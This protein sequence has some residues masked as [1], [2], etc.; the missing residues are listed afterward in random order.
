MIEP[1]LREQL[2]QR[3]IAALDLPAYSS[4]REL[5]P[6]LHA[7]LTAGVD[8]SGFQLLAD[9]DGSLEADEVLVIAR[10]GVPGNVTSQFEG[11]I[12]D[13]DPDG[14]FQIFADWCGFKPIDETQAAVAAGANGLTPSVAFRFEVLPGPEHWISLTAVQGDRHLDTLKIERFAGRDHRVSLGEVQARFDLFLKVDAD[15]SVAVVSS[16]IEDD[17][18]IT[19]LGCIRLPAETRDDLDRKVKSLWSREW[20]TAQDVD[21]ELER[22]GRIVAAALPDQLVRHL[23]TKTGPLTVLIEHGQNCDFPFELAYLADAEAE[24]RFLGERHRIIR[25]LPTSA[26]RP[27]ELRVA[28][29]ALIRNPG[30]LANSQS[31]LTGLVELLESLCDRVHPITTLSD[32]R[33]RVFRTS[34]YDVLDFVA[35]V[36][37]DSSRR[38]GLQLEEGH[39]NSHD[40]LI[41]AEHEFLRRKPFGFVNGCSATRESRGIFQST[42]FPKF[43]LELGASCF[44]GSSV[45]VQASDALRFAKALYLELNEDADIG[46]ATRRA[47]IQ[48][49]SHDCPAP[50]TQEEVELH[51]RRLSSLSYV[52]FGHPATK[53]RFVH[54]A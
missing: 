48:L 49:S 27:A 31:E 54:A 43:F 16:E 41:T 6:N 35:H 11:R 8:R 21:D 30:V 42:S 20:P 40:A 5:A 53:V 15:G 7:A 38:S 3:M 17:M 22:L 51:L 10:I 24:P 4:V 39:F 44:I 12:F 52:V 46:E 29:V 37:V 1:H 32:L 25:T 34:D 14:P 45:P 26:K 13:A 28:Q 47:R 9:V 23:A 50:S 33:S 36:S 2:L 19:N 18:L